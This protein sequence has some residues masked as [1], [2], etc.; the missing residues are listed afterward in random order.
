EIEVIEKAGSLGAPG[1]K[2]VLRGDAA[3]LNGE[4]LAELKAEL[5]KAR[6]TYSEQHPKVIRL[7]KQIEAMSKLRETAA[8]PTDQKEEI[9]ELR[10]QLAEL[11]AELAKLRADKEK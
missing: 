4:S 7:R 11:R 5:S 8:G 6:K 2:I 3:T 9:D 10:K 1:S